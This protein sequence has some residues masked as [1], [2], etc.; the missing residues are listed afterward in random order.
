MPLLLASWPALV[1]PEMLAHTL[2][3]ALAG[4][5]RF[6]TRMPGTPDVDGAP[7]VLLWIFTR[8]VPDAPLAMA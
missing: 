6:S 3:L 8:S 7:T 1:F 5:L 2:A 4:L